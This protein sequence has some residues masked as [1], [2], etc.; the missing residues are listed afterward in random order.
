MN[1]PGRVVTAVAVAGG[2]VLL[3]VVRDLLLLVF[4]GALFAV[5]L[6]SL[7]GQLR[8]VLPVGHRTA[9]VITVVVLLA[10]LL[11]LGRWFGNA[12]AAQVEALS[13]RLPVAIEA[14][15]HW[16][17]ASA[18]GAQVLQQ[19]DS[20]QG[21][22]VPWRRLAV[23]A[24]M[25]LGALGNLILL[26][27]VAVFVAA[28][29]RTYRDGALRLLP[30]DQRERVGA[31]LDGCATALRGWLRGQA[32]SM[33]FVGVATAVGLWFL[34]VPLALILG[35]VAALLNFVPFFGPIASGALAVLLAFTEGPRT[36]MYVAI[37][38]LVIQQLEGN[39]MMPLVQRWAV[40]LPPALG[41]I[42]VVLVAST[43]GL[44]GIV[45]ATPMVVVAMVLVR[46]LYV[47]DYLEGD[48][49]NP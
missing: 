4:G 31:A 46:K 30:V 11:A 5:V 37:L 21:G 24:G 34:D 10:L 27:L 13:E 1:Y 20:L 9:L 36:A 29:P 39:L 44:P 42:A 19:W 2:A 8:R 41:V 3:W 33:L 16:I 38:A 14:F 49:A 7:A 6:V 17:G 26:T 23:A 28:E 43:F 18:L 45:F 22:D 40:Q 12:V 48:T 35:L 47:E 32:V 15:R 25:T